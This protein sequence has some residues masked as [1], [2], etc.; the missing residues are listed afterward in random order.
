MSVTIITIFFITSNNSIILSVTVKKVTFSLVKDDSV[1]YI[2]ED[3]VKYAVTFL[4]LS[5]VFLLYWI[6][7]Q[8]LAMFHYFLAFYR[9]S[10]DFIYSSN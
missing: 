1:L 2:P 3:S 6:F 4:P 7:Q 10:P 5:S 9:A 8:H